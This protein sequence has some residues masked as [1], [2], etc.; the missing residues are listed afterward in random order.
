MVANTLADSLKPERSSLDLRVLRYFIAVA[1][2]HN[3]TW[4]AELLQVS[5]PTLSRQLKGLEEDLGVTLL[6]RGS[7][8]VELTTAGRLLYERAQTLVALADKTERELRESDGVLGGIVSIGCA[9]TRSMAFLSQR[10]KTF[11]AVHP[12]VRFDIRTMTADVAQERLEQGLLD[13]GLLVDPVDVSRYGYIRTHVTDRWGILMRPDHPLADRRVITPADLNGESLILTAREAPRSE[14]LN[15]L[16]EAAPDA[17]VAATSDLNLNGASM[18]REG[19]GLL[20]CFDS[21]ADILDGR[22]VFRPLEPGVE[23]G[24]VMVWKQGR[25]LSSAA[26]AFRKML[27]DESEPDAGGDDRTVS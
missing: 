4:A 15:W 20:F 9:E 22:L 26:S 1:E 23:T 27:H 13:F 3:I 25:T 14:E 21:S 18:V 19:V 5:Q 16:G 24:A 10:I 11:R 12:S 7:H 2:E 6:D 17:V 8:S